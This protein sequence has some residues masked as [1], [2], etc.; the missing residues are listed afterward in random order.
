MA[1][2]RLALANVGDVHLNHRNADGPDAIG[3]GDG[4]V[5]I[6][7]GVHHH[8]VVNAVGFLEFVDQITFMVRLVIVQF[9]LGEIP[10]HGFKM[11]FKR[12]VSVD[13]WLTSSQQIEIGTVDD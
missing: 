11:L 6:A 7:S 4:S 1:P 3:Q 5:G 13:L 12:N 10:T 2:V 8:P 9:H